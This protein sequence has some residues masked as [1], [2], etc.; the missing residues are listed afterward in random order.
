MWSLW[1]RARVTRL[2]P[3]QRAEM[4][5]LRRTPPNGKEDMQGFSSFCLI[6]IMENKLRLLQWNIMR[7]RAGMEA[8][9]N[10]PRVER[11]DLLLIQEAPRTT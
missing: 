2:P 7:S 11:F 10:D 4:H 5:R 1:W 8:L 3:R 9:I 6:E